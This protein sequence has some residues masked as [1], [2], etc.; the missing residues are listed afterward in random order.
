MV[1]IKRHEQLSHELFLGFDCS[2]DFYTP[3]T[4]R[5]DGPNFC[6]KQSHSMRIW[7]NA[8]SGFW[9]DGL[10]QYHGSDGW[11]FKE[12]VGREEPYI[13]GKCC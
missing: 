9:E 11:K 13:F 8:I 6:S 4:G 3:R 7:F 10:M 2:T 5:T 12:L 1:Q